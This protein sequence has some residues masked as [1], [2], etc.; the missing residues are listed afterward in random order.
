MDTAPPAGAT[1]ATGTQSKKLGDS[2][3]TRLRSINQNSLILWLLVAITSLVHLVHF[4][5]D[6]TVSPQI[7]FWVSALT[8]QFQ[9]FCIV[10]ASSLH[11]AVKLLLYVASHIL[12]V[13]VFFFL[14]F[15]RR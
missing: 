10:S 2:A 1:H 12:F 11:T 14:L 9:F 7:K 6:S 3:N 5:P 4:A 15:I 13:I 8:A